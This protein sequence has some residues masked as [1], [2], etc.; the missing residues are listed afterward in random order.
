MPDDGA[1]SVVA[2]QARLTVWAGEAPVGAPTVTGAAGVDRYRR[3]R[4]RG[5]DVAGRILGAHVEGVRAVALA[6]HRPRARAAGEAA[7]VDLALERRAGAIGVGEGV[8]GC[9]IVGQTD[10]PISVDVSGGVVSTVIAACDG[11]RSTLPAA[12]FALTEMV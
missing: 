1:G 7:G 3:A 11:V 6:R 9:R 8:A 2:D 12:S 5:V 4:R 10:G